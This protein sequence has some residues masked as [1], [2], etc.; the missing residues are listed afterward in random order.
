MFPVFPVL[1][2]LCSQFPTNDFIMF[3]AFPLSAARAMSTVSIFPSCTPGTLGTVG[4]RWQWKDLVVERGG[5]DV[6]R[7]GTNISETAID[8]FNGEYSMSITHCKPQQH[9]RVFLTIVR[10]AKAGMFSG[11]QSHLS[12]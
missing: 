3:P 6:E 2:P 5:T 4:T 7:L 10:P 12:R 8:P 1:F 11:R 9:V